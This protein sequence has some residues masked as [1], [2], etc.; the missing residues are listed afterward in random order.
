MLKRWR[1]FLIL[2]YQNRSLFQQHGS[3]GRISHRLSDRMAYCRLL[4]KN[5]SDENRR[6]HSHELAVCFPSCS[7]GRRLG[8]ICRQP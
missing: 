8:T 1:T 6:S 4:G 3:L 2:A 7:R 5:I